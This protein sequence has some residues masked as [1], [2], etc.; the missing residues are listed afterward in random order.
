MIVIEP[1]W[2]SPPLRSNDRHHWREKAAH[3]AV[4]R[5]CGKLLGHGQVRRH[6]AITGPVI[7]TLV[8]VVTDNRRRDVGSSSPTLKAFIDGLVDAKLIEDDHHKIV[9]EER[10]RIEV[11]GSK[12][13]RI[14]ISRIAE[15]IPRLTGGQ[16]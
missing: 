7:I 8:W 5:S 6:G 2:E 1:G 4:I 15:V 11:G 14:E 12:T 10:L 13:V 16:Q 9:T 3:T